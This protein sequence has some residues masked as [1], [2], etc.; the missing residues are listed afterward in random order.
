MTTTE[1]LCT[2]VGEASPPTAPRQVRTGY[3]WNP[4]DRIAGI[5]ATRAAVAGTDP[6]LLLV[7]PSFRDDL[8][9]LLDGVQEVASDVPLVGCTTAGEIGPGPVLCSGVLVV[10]LSGDFS[11]TT[12]CASGVAERPRQVGE[13]IASSLLPLP[14]RP[15]NAVVVLTDALFGNQQEMVRGAYGVLGASVPLVGGGA[16]DDMQMVT[17]RQIFDGKILQDTAVAA[18]IGS[19]APFGFSVRHGWQPQGEPFM[20]TGSSGN[21][22]YMLDDQPALDVY[23]NRHNAPPG[24]E[25]RPRDFMR[26]ALTRPLSVARRGDVA[27]RHVLGAYPDT[28]GLRCAGPVPRGATLWLAQGDVDSTLSSAD[29]ACAEAVSALPD[30]TP[31]GLFVF[32]CAGRRS[33][34]GDAGIREERRLIRAHAGGAPIAGFYCFGEVGRVRGAGGFHNQTIVAFALG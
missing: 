6:K 26:F 3:S 1:D 2:V 21:D 8:R 23:L 14:D 20:V 5:E 4:S 9:E 29:V 11:V 13:D 32:D 30:R 12:G 17:S 31:L 15:H 28:R 10:A 7:F 16:G 22:L 33:V 34:M 25:T 18:C 24:I 19:D 27:I